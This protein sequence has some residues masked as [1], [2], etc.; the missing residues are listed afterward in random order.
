MKELVLK[1]SDGTIKFYS[2]NLD[3]DLLTV[4]M[5]PKDRGYTIAIVKCGGVIKCFEMGVTP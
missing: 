2:R 5:T 3:G 1:R 4:V